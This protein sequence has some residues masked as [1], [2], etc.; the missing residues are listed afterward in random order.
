[1]TSTAS[2]SGAPG[3]VTLTGTA[4]QPAASGH[5]DPGV[6]TTIL[7]GTPGI[8]AGTL[9]L[10]PGHGNTTLTGQAS[11]HA[12]SATIVASPG[13]AQLHGQ[14]SGLVV[15]T[16]YGMAPTPGSIS[17]VVT[18]P[19]IAADQVIATLSGSVGLVGGSCR[20]AEQF[21]LS[22]DPARQILVGEPPAVAAASEI[23]AGSGRGQAAGAAPTVRGGIRLIPA[24]GG[25]A[26]QGGNPHATTLTR[27]GRPV[28]MHNH[29]LYVRGH[30]LRVADP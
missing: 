4:A 2:V 14:S 1:M 10:T 16:G 23:R 6:A 5:T 29:P 12:A 21:G 11:D 9:A 19:R 28:L 24:A 26:L 13:V 8:L 3:Y 30:L 27:T 22:P 20:V 25:M 15:G 18:S 7:A 17:V